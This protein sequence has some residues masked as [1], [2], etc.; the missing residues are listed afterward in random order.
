M[1]TKKLI[2]DVIQSSCFSTEVQYIDVQTQ[3]G[4]SDCGLFFVAFAITI[5]HLQD[6]ANIIYGQ[7][8]MRKTSHPLL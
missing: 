2:A 3:E 5:V 6:P 7:A 1:D 8:K 4:K